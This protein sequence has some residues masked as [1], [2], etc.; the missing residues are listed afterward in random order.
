MENTFTWYLVYKKQYE[1]Y[2]TVFSSQ[3]EIDLYCKEVHHIKK[4]QYKK[5][6]DWTITIL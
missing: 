5:N 2:A 4:V 1:V 3:Q 6:N